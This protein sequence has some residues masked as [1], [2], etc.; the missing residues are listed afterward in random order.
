MFEGVR[1]A[2]VLQALY[3]MK[4]IERHG[5]DEA[6]ELLDQAAERQGALVARE[7]RRTLPEGMSPLDMGAEAYRRFM[8][9]AG[10]EITEHRRDENSVTFAVRRCPYYEA[11]LDVGVDCGMFLNGLCGNLTLPS[12]QHTLRHL[13]PRLRVESV[14]TRE[15]A[16]ELCLERVVLGEAAQGTV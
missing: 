13:D 3:L 9:D 6:L 1:R 15:S 2:T 4:V 5:S 8:E 14:V 16:E 10:A 11:F 7:I 12:L